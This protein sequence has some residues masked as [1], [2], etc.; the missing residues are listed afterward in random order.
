MRNR[1]VLLADLIAIAAAVI[2]AFVLRFDWGAFPE[3]EELG[4]YLIAALVIKPVL[5]Y[6]F[7]MYSRYWR[8]T[9]IRD[10]RVVAPAVALSSVAMG[11]F[12]GV[13]LPA[14]LIEAF[15]RAVVV[16]DALL[17]LLAVC[18]IRLAIRVVGESRART[19]DAYARRPLEP[20]ATTPSKRILVVG[21]GEAGVMV[22]REMQRN[23]HLEMEPVGFLDDD[24]T[25]YG[26][27]IYGVPV[28][29]NLQSLGRIVRIAR[30]DEVV[31]AMPRAAGAPLRMVADMCRSLDIRS[32]TMPAV[33]ELLDGKVSVDR[34]RNIEITDLLKRPQ[35]QSRS[36]FE[37]LRG[38]TVLVTG[39]GG[40][41]GSELCRQVAHA[42]ARRVLMLGHGE[43]SLFEAHTQIQEQFP[44]VPLHI[45]VADIRDRARIERIFAQYEPDVVFHAAAHKHVHLM[46]EH[47]EEAISNN[48]V[49]TQIVV[50]AALATKTQR[51]VAIS[52]DKA[53][54]P[55]GIMGASKRMAGS[56]VRDAALRS[57]RKFLVVRFGNVLGSRGSVVPFFKRQI[58]RGG[59]VTITHPDMKRFFMTIPEAVH[60]VLEAAAMGKGGELFVLNMGKPVR[61]KD[62][63]EDLI[64]LSGFT[65]E[66]IPISISGMRPGE[67]MEEALWEE[68]AVV[69]PTA[70]QDILRVTESERSN[71]A[72]L[73][74]AVQSLELAAETGD[75]FSVEA[76]LCEWIPTFS[77]SVP[78]LPRDLSPARDYDADQPA[79]Q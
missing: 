69:E 27:R 13:A 50:E 42:R 75:R 76:V 41:I 14:D 22:V 59:P 5:F 56:I 52:T 57:G 19:R 34:L 15:S 78:L 35:V 55:N 32:R 25:K 48:I 58:E 26:K 4:P 37:Y 51:F 3:R 38:S 31:I 16:I 2:G 71:G 43:N 10:L 12:V 28:L 39:A 21:A 73:R 20:A 79:T 45:V 65:T 24:R 36:G 49:G 46:E 62:L 77:P 29:G 11:V 9:S 67:K 7:G 68:D 18:S 61:I 66:Q 33:F 6:M 30:V 8:Y 74:Q 44:D 63:A 64:R 70:H 40:S 72:D 53:V 17:T 1:Y 47:F 23:P 60:L 54:S